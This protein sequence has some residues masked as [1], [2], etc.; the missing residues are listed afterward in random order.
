MSETIVV[1]RRFNG[2]K[3]SANGGYFGGMIAKALGGTVAVS[4]RVPPPLDTPIRLERDDGG[5]IASLAD[6]TVVA[7]AEPATLVG[8][9]PPC[10]AYE[11]VLAAQPHYSGFQFHAL[12]GCFVCGPERVE[13][14]GLRIFASPMDGRE[15]VAAAWTPENDFATGGIVDEEFVWAALDCPAYFAVLNALGTK[16]EMILT[17]RMAVEIVAPVRAGEPHVVVGWCIKVEGRKYWAGT[18]IYTKQGTVAARAETLW[19]KPRS[20]D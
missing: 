2:P 9:V 17:G 18:A 14:D 19:I 7:H 13:G 1:D 5:L 8:D 3:E 15:L 11:D 10:P 12:P 20:K 6:G 4:L 16:G